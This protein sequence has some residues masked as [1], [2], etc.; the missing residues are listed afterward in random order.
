MGFDIK[1]AICV[2]SA[3]LLKQLG[4]AAKDTDMVKN[5]EE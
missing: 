5:D 3:M 1:R 2:F 4:E